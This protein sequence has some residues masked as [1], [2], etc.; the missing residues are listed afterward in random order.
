LFFLKA[1]VVF[2]KSVLSPQLPSL[3]VWILEIKSIKGCFYN[4]ETSIV[5]NI[6]EGVETENHNHNPQSSGGPFL[7]PPLFYPKQIG[8]AIP[9][10]LKD[11]MIMISCSM[12]C[13]ASS[14]GP[15]AKGAGKQ[16]A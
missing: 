13:N 3:I 10:A 1:L 8:Q 11:R 7:F 2:K 4:N 15:F 9:P 6:K 14:R 16:V 5:R 12:A